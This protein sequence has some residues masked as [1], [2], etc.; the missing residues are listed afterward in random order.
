MWVVLKFN[1]NNLSLLKK[2]FLKYL[3][4]DVKFYLPKL[5]LQKKK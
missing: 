1:K 3:G 4:N 5:K 2:D